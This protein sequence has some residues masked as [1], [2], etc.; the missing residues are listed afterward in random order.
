MEWS[1]YSDLEEDMLDEI[2]SQHQGS[3]MGSQRVEVVL[4]ENDC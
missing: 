2:G 1:G 4:G 3:D